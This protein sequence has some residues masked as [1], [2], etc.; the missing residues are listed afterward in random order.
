[1]SGSIAAARRAAACLL[2]IGVLA[3]GPMPTLAHAEL[4]EST[5]AANA[6]LVEAP[7][8]LTLSFSEPID[9]STAVV[10]LIDAQ[11]AGIDGL[12]EVR[13]GDDGRV[14]EV[15]LPDLEPGVYTVSYQVLSTVDGHATAGSFA[16][17]IDPSG[18]APPPTDSAIASSPSV[19][20]FTIAARWLALAAILVAFG[21]LVTWWH[22][23]R[24]VLDARPPWLLVAGSAALAAVGVAAYLVLSARPIAGDGQSTGIP[25]DIA[26]PFGWTP[27]AIAMRVAFG[28]SLAA[29]LA[30]V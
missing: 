12:G 4:V 10:E 28:A 6:S 19:D 26:S 7:E 17:L 16:F 11:Q 8:A 15:S 13:V 29:A 9:P 18:A 27:F 30:A 21:S 14:V 22:A 24:P 3:I 1:M 23:G 2:A 25:L 5:P 20:P